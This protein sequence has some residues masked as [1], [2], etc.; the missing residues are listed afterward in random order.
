MH[1]QGRGVPKDPSEAL[2]LY[3]LAAAKGHAGAAERLR[4]SRG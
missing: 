2:R 4:G 3:G 1:E